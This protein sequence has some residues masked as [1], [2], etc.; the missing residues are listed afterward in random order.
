MAGHLYLDGPADYSESVAYRER[1]PGSA[2]TVT[3]TLE[4]ER[5][6]LGDSGD[7][8]WHQGLEFFRFESFDA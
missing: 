7:Q 2:V 4:L 8:S 6:L 5:K 1:Q 3:T